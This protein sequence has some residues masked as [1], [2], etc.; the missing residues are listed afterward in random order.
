MKIIQEGK[1]KWTKKFTCKGCEAVLEADED[2]IQY[3]VTDAHAQAQHEQFEIEGDFIV[4]CPSCTQ[5]VKFRDLPKN[6]K[7]QIKSRF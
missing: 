3:V 5:E 6:L 7:E 2:D 1:K 4:A